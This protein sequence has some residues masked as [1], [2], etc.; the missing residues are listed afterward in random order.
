MAFSALLLL[1]LLLEL[2][3]NNDAE[4]CEDDENAETTTALLTLTSTMD[5]A[6]G[7]FIVL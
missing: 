5:N 1:P 2:V 4:R 3:L 6:D 7:N